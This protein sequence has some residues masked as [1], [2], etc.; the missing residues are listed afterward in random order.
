MTPYVY[1]QEK[2][3]NFLFN[4]KR[5]ESKKLGDLLVYCRKSIIDNAHLVSYLNKLGLSITSEE[6]HAG[7]KIK[8][9]ILEQIDDSGDEIAIRNLLGSPLLKSC[10]QPFN[11]EDWV[12]KRG[13]GDNN[14]RNR[15]YSQ[16]SVLEVGDV[17]ITGERVISPPREGGNGAVLV[18][19]S[20][21]KMGTWLSFPSRIALALISCHDEAVPPN[22]IEDD[23]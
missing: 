15:C 6:W 17:L 21:C 3:I 11:L 7:I 18:H 20:G 4:L 22:L 14:L 16:P 23:Q 5:E 2:L 10:T 1:L 13:S 19:L 9:L 12:N 8:E